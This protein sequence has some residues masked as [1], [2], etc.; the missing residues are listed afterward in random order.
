MSYNASST[1]MSFLMHSNDGVTY[2]K[3]I[4]IKNYP[5]MGGRK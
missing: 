5:D 3:L 4:D 2:E 1:Y